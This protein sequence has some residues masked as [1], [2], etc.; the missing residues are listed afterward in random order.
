MK[1]K[2][3]HKKMEKEIH[4]SEKKTLV[5]KSNIFI[6]GRYRFGLH[7]Q[8]ILLLVVSK[9]KMNQDD[10]IPYRVTWAEI[11]EISKGYLD[12][13][14][15]IDK[16]CESLK[17]KTIS[18]RNGN[19]V[20]N[21]GFLSGWTT[22]QGQYVEFRVDPSMKNMLLGLLEEGHFTL[23]DLEFALALPSAHS[24]RIYEIL[25]SHSWKKQP[26]E[27]ALDDLKT[28]LDIPLDSPTYKDFGNFR[29]N[30][31]APSQKN[32]KKHTDISFTFT[33][34]KVM[35]RVVALSLTIRENKKF[36]RTVQAAAG[37]DFVRPGDRVLIGG[38]ECQVD[39]SGLQ[40]E[41][42]FFPIGQLTTLLRQG[43]IKLLS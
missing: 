18:I 5:R 41:T 2:R 3:S 30:V 19:V 25:K 33:T 24:V 27:I 10:F 40:Y 12:T 22:H 21:F 31:L 29:Q 16:A 23:Y 13:V 36:Q 11:K 34:V 20:D 8:K 38:K 39:G 32:L 14:S 42:G 4:V 17:N 37:R 6:D 15:K 43:K 9:I 28:A 26:V 7:E 1:R 35:R